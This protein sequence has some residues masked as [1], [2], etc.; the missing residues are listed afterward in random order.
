MEMFKLS[1]TRHG[2]DGD[3]YKIQ[4]LNMVIEAMKMM[5]G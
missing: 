3:D 4:V 2:G 1:S 5:D